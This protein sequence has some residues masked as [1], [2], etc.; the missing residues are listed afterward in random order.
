MMLFFKKVHV[1][2]FETK[3]SCRE[4]QQHISAHENVYLGA[5]RAVVVYKYVDKYKEGQIINFVYLTCDCP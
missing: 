3:K 2:R 1:R 5:A 4:R